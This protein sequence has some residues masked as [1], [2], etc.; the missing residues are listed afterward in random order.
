MF[1]Q[2]ALLRALYGHCTGTVRAL[3]SASVFDQQAWGGGSS[4]R[5]RGARYRGR[6][7]S[8]GSSVFLVKHTMF[9]TSA[10]GARARR[11]FSR[12]LSGARRGRLL[13]PSPRQPP[14]P[15]TCNGWSGTRRL[16]LRRAPLGT[17]MPPWLIGGRRC[18]GSAIAWRSLAA[19]YHFAP[20][21]LRNL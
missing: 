8:W 16:I 6:G 12:A 3:C 7:C 19:S 13:A 2:R 11:A 4:A 10:F 17:P 9:C 1:S 15:P 14:P 21:A 20:A 5:G 18:T